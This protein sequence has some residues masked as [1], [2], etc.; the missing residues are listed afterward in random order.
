MKT[1]PTFYD[2]ID[3]DHRLGDDGG[4]SRNGRHQQ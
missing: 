4:A 3:V 1:I 2:G